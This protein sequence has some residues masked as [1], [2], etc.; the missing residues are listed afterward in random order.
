M[1]GNGPPGRH[2]RLGRHL[3]AK[4]A[5]RSSLMALTAKDV[6]F[7]ELQREQLDEGREVPRTV[8]HPRNLSDACCFGHAACPPR[9]PAPPE[10]RSLQGRAARGPQ[11]EDAVRAVRVTTL[12]G[13][14]A[15][16]FVEVAEPTPSGSQVLIEV[17]AAGVTF[18]D[19][20]MTRGEY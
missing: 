11:E 12:D 16:E 7:D 19:L 15:V 5:Q 14:A 13:P 17:H 6:L 8:V 18:P 20:L 3:T 4:G 10:F 9:V 2:Q 1:I